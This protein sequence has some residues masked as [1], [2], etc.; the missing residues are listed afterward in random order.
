M[1]PPSAKRLAGKALALHK[2]PVDT[3]VIVKEAY[4]FYIMESPQEEAD[5]DNADLRGQENYED[6]K[7]NGLIEEGEW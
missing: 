1:E 2:N 6:I 4:R 7:R 5:D 3:A